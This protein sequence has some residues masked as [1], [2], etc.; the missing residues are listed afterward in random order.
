MDEN[1]YNCCVFKYFFLKF[2][3]ISLAQNKNEM[4]KM[5]VNVI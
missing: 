3:Q 1:D 4:F 5:K 2:R